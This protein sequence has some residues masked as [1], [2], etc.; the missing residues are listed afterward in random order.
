MRVDEAGTGRLWRSVVLVLVLAY[1]A[2]CF[3]ARIGAMAMVKV[4]TVLKS[5]R[6][7]E[8]KSGLYLLGSFGLWWNECVIR[9]QRPKETG[10]EGP[11]WG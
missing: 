8:F 7:A 11:F 2:D 9:S 1:P 10:R 4:S 3:P 5:S 6:R